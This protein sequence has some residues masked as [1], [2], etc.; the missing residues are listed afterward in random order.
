PEPLPTPIAWRVKQRQPS[1]RS[2]A[3]RTSPCSGRNTAALVHDLPET[4]IANVAG[5]SSYVR[6]RVLTNAGALDRD[7]QLAVVSQ[8]TDRVVAAA[9][10]PTVRDRTWVLQTEAPDGGL[11]GHAH[12]ND[13]L[14]AAARAEIA[15]LRA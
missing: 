9:N 3:S 6:V 8:L 4:H 13:E 7:K 14:V 2:R 5:D 15:K 12:A 11:W 10:D 1:R